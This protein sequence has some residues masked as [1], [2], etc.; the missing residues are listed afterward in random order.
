MPQYKTSHEWKIKNTCHNIR[1]R[2]YEQTHATISDNSD[3]KK[4]YAT[5]KKQLTYAKQHA[6]IDNIRQLTYEKND[7]I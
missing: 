4:T 5:I 2:T 7:T 3:M 1:Q 6:T